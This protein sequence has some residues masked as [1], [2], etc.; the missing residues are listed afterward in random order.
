MLN[1]LMRQLTLGRG[2]GQVVCRY[3]GNKMYLSCIGNEIQSCM[4]FVGFF[5]VVV[6][7]V[8]ARFLCLHLINTRKKKEEE[9][10]NIKICYRCHR[11]LYFQVLY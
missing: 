11:N 5:V 7:V 8:F 2:G 9:N 1:M 4:G 10:G 6:V 3:C